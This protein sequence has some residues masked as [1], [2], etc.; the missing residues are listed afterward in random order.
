MRRVRSDPVPRLGSWIEKSPE[1]VAVRYDRP[2]PIYR[3]FEGLYAL[4][5]PGIPG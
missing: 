2:A 5:Q 1:C 3:A 4:P